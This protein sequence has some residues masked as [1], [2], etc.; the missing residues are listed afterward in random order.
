MQVKME[1]DKYLTPETFSE[2]TERF[3]ELTSIVQKVDEMFSDI[4]AMNLTLALGILC[5]AIYSLL[6][7]TGTALG[8]AI[9]ILMSVSILLTLL[10][11]VTAL[12]SKVNTENVLP[13]IKS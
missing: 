3:Y 6:K 5:F 11:S 10:P 12:N 2:T 8:W 1:N 7:H 4:V 13:L 9:P